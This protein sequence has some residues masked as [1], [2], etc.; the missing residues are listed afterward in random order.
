MLNISAA[1]IGSLLL[2]SRILVLRWQEIYIIFKLVS[3]YYKRIFVGESDAVDFGP[4][5]GRPN[6]KKYFLLKNLVLRL[7]AKIPLYKNSFIS[8]RKSIIVFSL[9]ISCRIWSFG[10]RLN[11]QLPCVINGCSILVLRLQAKILIIGPSMADKNSNLQNY[12]S[13][14]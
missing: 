14:D 5:I 1:I 2:S 7:S 8:F 12:R 4:S 9:L 3:F 10:I 11:Y 6:F 13:F